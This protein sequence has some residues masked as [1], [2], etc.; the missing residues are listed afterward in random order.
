MSDDQAERKSIGAV[1]DRVAKVERDLTHINT[2]FAGI[3]ASLE[4]LERNQGELAKVVNNRGRTDWAVVATL[5]GG[6]AALLVFYTGL[7][8]EPIAREQIQQ[9]DDYR[10]ELAM[11]REFYDARIVA[12]EDNIDRLETAIDTRTQERYT[13]SD[14]REFVR[15]LNEQIRELRKP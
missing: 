2:A 1:F 9:Q 15:E 4:R 6:V 5:G 13:K 3:S 8:T 11:V 7:V 10:H 14:H 12:I